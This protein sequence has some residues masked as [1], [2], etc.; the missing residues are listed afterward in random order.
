[1]SPIV[2]TSKRS[3]VLQTRPCLCV[4]D[5]HFLF[6]LRSPSAFT[7]GCRNSVFYKHAHFDKMRLL[8]FSLH[9]AATGYVF[10]LSLAETCRIFVFLQP[11]LPYW[12]LLVFSQFTQIGFRRVIGRHLYSPSSCAFILLCRFFL[13]WPSLYRLPSRFINQSS[14][15]V[16]R[17]A[18]SG[19]FWYWSWSGCVTPSILAL[20]DATPLFL[21]HW[22]RSLHG[23]P[24]TAILMQR[25]L[26]GGPLLAI[27]E[28]RYVC[29][30]FYA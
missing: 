8:F 27:G 9:V 1:M 5:P 12:P 16:V 20:S 2:C 19:V 26:H 22:W 25:S 15:T 4:L 23:D 17:T 6:S 29:H 28:S 13:Q 21:R 10:W 3:C 7:Q 11:T 24:Y 14:F 18:L 30:A